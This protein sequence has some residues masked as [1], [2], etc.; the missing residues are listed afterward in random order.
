MVK[1]YST[2][3][4]SWDNFVGNLCY[5]NKIWIDLIYSICFVTFYCYSYP[6][7]QSEGYLCSTVTNKTKLM[8]VTICYMFTV[9]TFQNGHWAHCRNRWC[10]NFN[11]RVSD[12]QTVPCV[13]RE[14]YCLQSLCVDEWIH[15]GVHNVGTGPILC[16]S[17]SLADRP[18][19]SRVTSYQ[20][21]WHILSGMT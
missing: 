14:W 13:N 16:V 9:I 5:I 15:E 2:C 6:V 20:S 10:V 4:L 1:T 17:S 19:C 11:V 8:Y 21:H 12:E 3:K 18:I 7:G